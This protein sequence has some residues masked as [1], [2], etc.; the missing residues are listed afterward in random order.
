VLIHGR[1]D[2]GCPI[3]AAWELAKAM[4]GARLLIFED[5]GHA[6]SDAMH[7]VARAAIEE[8]KNQ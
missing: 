3:Q 8:F 4:P 6:G 7:H 2:M 1:H 5:A